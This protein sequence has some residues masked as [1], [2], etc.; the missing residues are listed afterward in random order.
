LEDEDCTPT[1]T[2]TAVTAKTTI[3]MTIG[4]LERFAGFSDEPLDC[5]GC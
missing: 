5:D 4:M 3:N 2:P 1:P